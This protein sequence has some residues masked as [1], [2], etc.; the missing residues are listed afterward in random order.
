MFSI[1]LLFHVLASIIF[2]GNNITGA[3]WKARADKTGNVDIISNSAKALLRADY[4]FTLP[5][6][7]VLFVTGVWMGGLSGWERFQEIWLGSSFVL[8]VITV[9][10][11]VIVLSPRL[12]TLVRIATDCAETGKLSE[13]YTAVSRTWSI[14]GGV[15]TL[16]PIVILILMVLKPGL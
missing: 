14:W 12:R 6:L 11:W 8:L 15:V 7:I 13:G 9:L 4:Q 5:S 2:I 16:L 3:F 1:L 10:I